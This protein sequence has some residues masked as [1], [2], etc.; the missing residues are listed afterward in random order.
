MSPNVPKLLT[1]LNLFI[2]IR[3][4]DNNNDFQESPTHKKYVASWKKTITQYGGEIETMISA[5]VTH[6]L[7]NSQVGLFSLFF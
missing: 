2:D 7:C 6:L 4:C 5:R 3:K 1:L